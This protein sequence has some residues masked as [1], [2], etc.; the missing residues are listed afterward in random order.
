MIIFSNNCPIPLC[1]YLLIMFVLSS[2]DSRQFQTQTSP[3]FKS[4]SIQY[5][6]L[7]RYCYIDDYS[8]WLQRRYEFMIWFDLAK[9]LR[10]SVDENK[11]FQRELQQYRLQ[12][13]CL[14]FVERLPVSVGPG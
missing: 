6:L 2:V 10:L 11:E 12:Y 14:R 1:F 4:K 13:E 9:M 7:V 5:K 8:A 3:P